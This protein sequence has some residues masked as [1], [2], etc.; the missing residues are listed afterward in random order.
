MPKDDSDIRVARYRFLVNVPFKVTEDQYL[1]TGAEYNQVVV[2]SDRE[3]PFDE[4]QIEKLHVIDLNLGYIFKWNEDWRFVAI[5][6]PRLA[7]NLV[8]GIQGRDLK[9]NAT[10]TFW[11]EKKDA[12]KPYRLVLGLSYNATT[13]L[14]FPLPLVSYYRRFHPDWSFALGVPKSQLKYHLDKRHTLE[15][16]LFLDGYFVNIQDD[17]I[18]DDNSRAASISLS[19]LVAALGYQYNIDKHISLFA[20]AGYTVTQDGVLR[21]DRRKNV[22]V[23]NDQGNIYFRTGFKVSLF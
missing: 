18:F 15:T 5:L 8:G 23:L 17:L 11:K 6:S 7:S 12:E 21:D 19:A 16:A 4:K 9:M 22:Y 3:L 14:P 10:A 20:M 1:V 13:G 2:G